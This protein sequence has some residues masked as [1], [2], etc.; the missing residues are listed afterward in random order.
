MVGAL[1]TWRMLVAQQGSER[2]AAALESARALQAFGC[3]WKRW[4]EKEADLVTRVAQLEREVGQ[5]PDTGTDSQPPPA[6]DDGA[7]GA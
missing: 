7:S 5:P 1:T 6:V 4:D 3:E 2:W